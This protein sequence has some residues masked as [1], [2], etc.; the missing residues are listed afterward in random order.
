MLKCT[1]PMVISN[2]VGSMVFPERAPRPGPLDYLPEL[3]PSPTV[4]LKWMSRNGR[5]HDF[6]RPLK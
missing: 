5:T 3:D 4:K 1:L 6:F 2:F